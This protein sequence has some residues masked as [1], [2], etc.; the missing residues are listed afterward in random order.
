MSS[1]SLIRYMGTGVIL[2]VIAVL[3]EIMR[4]LC[5]VVTF[6][7]L[8]SRG[9]SVMDSLLS[10]DHQN[11]FLIHHI[12]FSTSFCFIAGHLVHIPVLL[13]LFQYSF[14]AHNRALTHIMEPLD[15]EYNHLH[16]MHD[17]T[18]NTCHLYVQGYHIFYDKTIKQCWRDPS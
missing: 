14:Q 7:M 3:C 13:Q 18:D 2:N 11:K 12:F 17:Y 8:C 6:Q 9:P 16:L 4:E 1:P 15:T 10:R 5:V